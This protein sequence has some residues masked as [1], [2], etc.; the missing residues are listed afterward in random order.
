MAMGMP[1]G[2]QAMLKDG[3]KHFSGVDEAVL[4]NIDACKALAQ[5]TRTSL[6]PNGRV[7]GSL[8][9]LKNALACVLAASAGHASASTAAAG[10][11]FVLARTHQTNTHNTTLPAKQHKIGMNKMVI[12][13]LEK[14]FVTSDASTIVTELEVMHPAAK[15]LVMAAKAQAGEVGD[16]TNLV[17]TLAG[18]L[19]NHAEGLLRDGLHT[20]EI[21]DAQHSQ[22]ALNQSSC[23]PRSRMTCR[24]PSQR[25]RAPK[26]I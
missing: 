19:L 20:T 9:D 13:H 11:F 10:W 21:A 6:G 16:G 26:P 15:L 14:L 8:C 7:E 2:L 22:L 1:Y 17:L 18:E 4:K 12:N 23:W 25:A 3:H 5:I 24:V